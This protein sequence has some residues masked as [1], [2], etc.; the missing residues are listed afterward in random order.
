M[1]VGAAFLIA[2][3]SSS[4]RVTRWGTV[5]SAGGGDPPIDMSTPT[6]ARRHDQ[7]GCPAVSNPRSPGERAAADRFDG[8]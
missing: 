1:K 2:R 8:R 5:V 6:D 4:G 3:V 7:V